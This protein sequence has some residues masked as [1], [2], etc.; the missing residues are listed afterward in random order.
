VDNLVTEQPVGDNASG[1]PVMDGRGR[2]IRVPVIVFW[3]VSV[4]FLLYLAIGSVEARI[5]RFGR[6]N[7]EDRDVR[8]VWSYFGDHLPDMPGQSVISA[9]YWISLGVMVIGTILGLWLFLGTEDETPSTD[10]VGMI[11]EQMNTHD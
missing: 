2:G 10:D 11:S 7:F 3:V 5:W 8:H 1:Q 4:A 6:L 9:L